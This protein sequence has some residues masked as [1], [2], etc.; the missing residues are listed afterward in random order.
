MKIGYRCIYPVVIMMLVLV[1]QA[2]KT[3][4]STAKGSIT[5]LILLDGETDH[6]GI[7]VSIFTA[8]LVPEKV[9]QIRQDYPQL[10]F[11]INDQVIFDHRDYAPLKTVFTSESGS[12]TFEKLP[13]GEYIIAYS[14][15][16][17]GYN[18][19]YDL[20]LDS[21]KL[22]LGSEPQL[23]LYE[24]I[25]LPNMISGNI[26]LESDKCYVADSDVVLDQNASLLFG[27]NARLLL[28]PYVKII[29]QGIIMGP[30][31]SQRAYVTSYSG[32]HPDVPLQ[33]GLAEG[34]QLIR[35]GS[36]LDNLSFSYLSIGLKV[37]GS[38]QVMNRLS[39]T[40]CVTGLTINAA[41][42]ASL[43]NSFFANN[44]NTNSAACYGYD[45]Q[46]L[47]ASYNVFYNNFIA[48]KHEIVKNAIIENNA[49]IDNNRA[50]LNLW[51]STADFRYNDVRSDGV[52][53]EN[54]GRSNLSITYNNIESKVGVKT[55]HT[56]NWYNLP[57]AG[58]TSGGYN[59]FSPSQYAVQS[60][61]R[62]YNNGESFP[63]DFRN[64]FFNTTSQDEIEALI[65]DVHDL[66]EPYTGS[67]WAIINYLPFRTSSIPNAGIQ[68]R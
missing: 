51:E 2:C 55:Y 29:A 17:W 56:N 48:Q 30:Q 32:V 23:S 45:V 21:E 6:S 57:N 38:D 1:M 15:E 10:A 50:Y 39:F 22:I 64:N 60:E 40:N 63:L 47:S 52:A 16:G 62:Y 8:G 66:P 42:N 12:F 36:Q 28:K 44:L 59:N 5:G 27:S 24:E 18:Y 68:I 4:S 33:M 67:N 41:T 49:Y 11:P 43:R 20:R 35:S 19:L 31:A 65:Y 61:A 7:V 9:R 37:Q 14:K 26:I 34:L 3:T 13:Y 58:W 53:I 54:S 46:G 25:M